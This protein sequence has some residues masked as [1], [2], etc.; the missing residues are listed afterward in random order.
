MPRGPIPGSGPPA[1]SGRVGARRPPYRPPA[2][3]VAP[4][5]VSAAAFRAEPPPPSLTQRLRMRYA[6]GRRPRASVPRRWPCPHPK[7]DGRNP[8]PRWLT[9]GDTCEQVPPAGGSSL[10]GPTSPPRVGASPSLAQLDEAIRAFLDEYRAS[11]PRTSPWW[12]TLLGHRI[13]PSEVAAFEGHEHG[14][15]VTPPAGA[16]G[17]GDGFISHRRE[18]GCAGALQ[19]LLSGVPR[20]AT[21]AVRRGPAHRRQAGTRRGLDLHPPYPGPRGQEPRGDQAVG[22]EGRGPPTARRVGP[23]G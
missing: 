22:S 5:Q 15:M 9:G 3:E 20:R 18:V 17:R 10:T 16:I 6:A 19:R 1:T 21:L 4:E 2:L 11:P 14:E 7:G 12:S 23:A 8:R 13:D